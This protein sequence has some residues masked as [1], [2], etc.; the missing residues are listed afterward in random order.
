MGAYNVNCTADTFAM[1]VYY[2]YNPQYDQI[3]T[4]YQYSFCATGFD[5]TTDACC[6]YE[7]APD[8]KTFPWW[9]VWAGISA[10]VVLLMALAVCVYVRRKRTQSMRESAHPRETETLDVVYSPDPKQR[11]ML[12]QQF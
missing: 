7:V 4:R 5:Y 11:A 3:F 12:D 8:G 10:F 9:A 6:D 2:S 1:Y